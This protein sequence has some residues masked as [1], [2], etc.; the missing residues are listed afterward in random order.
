MRPLPDAPKKLPSAT[1]LGRAPRSTARLRAGPRRAGHPRAPGGLHRE[2]GVAPPHPGRPRASLAARSGSGASTSCPKFVP[3]FCA[4][5]FGVW[6]RSEPLGH[7]DLRS[8]LSISPAARP[9]G[10]LRSLAP[11]PSPETRNGLQICGT[12]PLLRPLTAAHGCE[13]KRKNEN[14]QAQLTVPGWRIL[15]RRCWPPR[16]PRRGRT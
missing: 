9:F 15:R 3:G 16:S 5:P 14:R 7:R 10:T 12:R 11:P 6:G 1:D 4:T 13:R 2:D 8:V